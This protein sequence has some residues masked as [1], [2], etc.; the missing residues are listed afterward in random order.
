VNPLGSIEALL[1]RSA[2]SVLSPAGARGSL[3]VLIYHRVLPSPDELLP[4]EPD[5]AAFGAQLDLLKQLFHVLPL[6]EAA[7]RL[8][9]NSLPARALCITFDDG[10]ANNCEIAAPLLRAR[11]MTATFFVAVSFLGGG[12]MFND[13]VIET[14][15]GA[16]EHLNLTDLG[17]GQFYLKD[18]ASR[19]AAIGTLLNGIKYLEPVERVRMTERI[20]ERA[21]VTLPTN[22]MMTSDQVRELAGMGM[23]VGAHTLTHPILTRVD[24]DNARRE[25]LES[26]LQLESML[27]ARVRTFAYPNGRPQRDY[28]KTHV[29][30]VREAG[31]DAAVS[32]GWGKATAAADPFQIPRVA[33]WDRTARRYAARMVRCYVQ[34]PDNG[35]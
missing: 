8:R 29:Q 5:A 7:E 11:G 2:A 33:P 18:A 28:D 12:R 20:A 31:F 24:R 30:L 26:K 21:G 22:L 27:G 3:L 16:P 14:I 34:Q 32:T 15:R 25:I 17:L 19:R 23:E 1:L 35:V 9:A 10:Y 6:A 4:D 13:S